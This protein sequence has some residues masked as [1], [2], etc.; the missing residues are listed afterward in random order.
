MSLGR[1]VVYFLIRKALLWH[2]SRGFQLLVVGLSS[3]PLLQVEGRDGRDVVAEMRCRK[4]V[5]DE[6]AKE[7]QCP[8]MAFAV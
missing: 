4:R 3:I 2:R 8:S 6:Y 1:I 5:D 7:I